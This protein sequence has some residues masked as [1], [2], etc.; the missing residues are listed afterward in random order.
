LINRRLAQGDP[1][2]HPSDSTIWNRISF[3]SPRFINKKR[4]NERLKDFCLGQ[5][6]LRRDL[7]KNG[8]NLPIVEEAY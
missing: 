5:S 6:P 4:F 8:I 2:T 7:F 1:K 3:G